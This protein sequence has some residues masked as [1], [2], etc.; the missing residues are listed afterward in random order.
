MSETTRETVEAFA[1]IVAQRVYEA[2]WRAEGFRDAPWDWSVPLQ[3]IA[4]DS[5]DEFYRRRAL[6]SP[7]GPSEA[8]E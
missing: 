7:P 6:S 8:R 5:V 2:C 3:S 4:H 1:L